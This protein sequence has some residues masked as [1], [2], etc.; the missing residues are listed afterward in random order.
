LIRVFK[1][2]K[3]L[4]F[5]SLHIILAWSSDVYIKI[6]L[7]INWFHFEFICCVFN[8]HIEVIHGSEKT[9]KHILFIRLKNIYHSWLYWS[10]SADS[11]LFYFF[12]LQLHVKLPCCNSHSSAWNHLTIALLYNKNRKDYK[13]CFHVSSSSYKNFCSKHYDY[14]S[15]SRGIRSCQHVVI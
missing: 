11:L 13:L 3:K 12:S 14:I 1:S 15:F 7:N 6:R 2:I 8:S 10:P 5:I 9:H 4:K